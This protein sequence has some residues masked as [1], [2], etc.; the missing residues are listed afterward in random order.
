MGLMPPEQPD[1]FDQVN[2][3]FSEALDLPLAGREA[4]VRRETDSEA[5]FSEVIAMLAKHDGLG[6]FL[7]EPAVPVPPVR[8][9]EIRKGEILSGRFRVLELLGRGGMGEVYRADDP[10]SGEIVALKTLRSKFLGDPSAEER[11]RHELTLAR[12]ISHVNVCRIHELF[13]E[14]RESGRILYFTMEYLDGE[15]LA[16]KLRRGSLSTSETLAIGR[17]VAAGM[18]AAHA[19]G[20][21]HRDLKPANVFLARD[22]V[23]VT[24]FG[25]AK[26]L[27][28]IE[29][30]G[31]ETITGQAPGTPAYMS[32]EQFLGEGLTPQSDVFAFGLIVFEMLTGR[33]PFPREDVG[34]AIRRAAPAV[35][36]E[37]GAAIDR[38]LAPIPVKRYAT[39]GAMVQDLERLKGHLGPPA[40]LD[41][42]KLLWGCGIGAIFVASLITVSRIRNQRAALPGSPVL[43][44]TPLTHSSD[45]LNAQAVAL[46]LTEEPAQSAHLRLLSREDVTQGWRRINASN[47]SA[48]L[49]LEPKM[50]RDI[51]L[52]QGADFVVFGNLGN[53]GDEYVLRLRIELMGADPA[54]AHETWAHDFAVS[55]RSDLPSAAFDGARWIR[56]TVGESAPDVR[57]RSRRPEEMTTSSWQALEEFAKADQA[58]AVRDSVAALLHLRTALDLDKGFALAAFRT[59]DILAATHRED[60]ALPY[61]QTAADLI[62]EKNLTDRESLRIRGLF[63]L[64]TRQDAEAERVFTRWAMEYPRDPLPLFYKATSLDR[65]GRVEEALPLGRKAMELDPH[66]AVFVQADAERLLNAGRI[67]ESGVQAKRLAAIDDKDWTDIL[68]SALAIG[69][70]DLKDAWRRLEH[71]ASAGTPY[72]HSLA[73]VFQACFRAEQKHYAEAESLY[74]EGMAFDASNGLAS[75]VWL[76]KRQ[77]AQL[78]L[79]QNRVVEAAG[80]CRE[81]LAAAPGH[82]L[83]MEIGCILAQAGAV[84]AARRCLPRNLADWPIYRHWSM[85]LQGAI[86]LAS[87]D[88]IH[89]LALTKEAPVVVAGGWREDILNAALAAGDTVLARRLLDEL[90]SN[91]GR[92]WRTAQFA[93]PGFLSRAANAAIKVDIAPGTR[94]NAESLKKS[95]AE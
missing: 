60:E 83:A 3:I 51:A 7:D 18:D 4:F 16:D 84:A 39:A 92:A 71:L 59:A 68:L 20:I 86:A 49:Q 25:L 17:Q 66:R 9:S 13:G 6:S 19:A 70:L 12:K 90:F 79:G 52:R 93:S 53:T 40:T 2:R 69:R 50:A 8:E 46:L 82:Q 26:A 62:R 31:G 14:E 89:G 72:F 45:E 30:G 38:A 1:R 74:L 88:V 24:D 85:R 80:L 64:D 10:L 54:H 29:A 48:P 78:F 15:T 63:L 65:Q 28:V 36:V 73:Y 55:G 77:L 61:Y 5:I 58:W 27:Q 21:L 11:F 41:R 37:W 33:P 35:P 76:K 43:M 94:N 67:V 91:P 56:E 81:I 57:A 23:V 75:S 22:R 47:A 44:P 42:R 87:G 95:F 34:S 32:P